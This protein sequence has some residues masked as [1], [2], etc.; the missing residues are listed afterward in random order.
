MS[1]P[2]M[3]R[4]HFN[5]KA[6]GTYQMKFSPIAFTAVEYRYFLCGIQT[7]FLLGH[8]QVMLK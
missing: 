7:D 3:H 4:G 1:K 6:P 5:M 2:N 8:L